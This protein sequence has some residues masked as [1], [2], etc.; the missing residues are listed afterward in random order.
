MIQLLIE[1]IQNTLLLGYPTSRAKTE[2]RAQMSS[3]KLSTPVV[4]MAAMN[5][6][7]EVDTDLF[8]VGFEWDSK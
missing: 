5:K 6:L 3:F 2:L 7:F 1:N 8:S 4:V